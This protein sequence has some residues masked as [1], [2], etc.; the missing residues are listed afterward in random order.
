MKR[1]FDIHLLICLLCFCGIGCQKQSSL[2][3]AKKLVR[4]TNEEVEE[5]KKYKDF[6]ESHQDDKFKMRL[7]VNVL[8]NEYE[9][10]DPK[11]VNQGFESQAWVP[12]KVLYK[13][14]GELALGHKLKM[15]RFTGPEVIGSGTY[16][17]IEGLADDYVESVAKELDGEV[18]SLGI[19]RSDFWRKLKAANAKNG[20]V[21]FARENKLDETSLNIEKHQLNANAPFYQLDMIVDHIELSN[22]V[23]LKN[24]SN[25]SLACEKDL[26]T[27]VSNYVVALHALPSLIGV[28][29][30]FDELLKSRDYFREES[31]L[32]HDIYYMDIIFFN[33]AD[34]LKRFGA[35]NT[36][37]L[38]YRKVAQAIA[39]ETQ[40]VVK[41]LK[42]LFVDLVN[43]SKLRRFSE[44]SD[45]HDQSKNKNDQNTNHQ[46]QLEHKRKHSKVLRDLIEQ[47]M[48]EFPKKS[49]KHFSKLTDQQRRD[50]CSSI[51]GGSSLIQCGD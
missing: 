32:G 12:D 20:F 18:S 2:N 49:Q 29:N 39:Q 26:N 22:K 35:G 6:Y 51:I 24:K 7:N 21:Y 50:L 47:V 27:V 38:E 44:T 11:K 15:R 3:D 48:K 28:L 34:R 5:I 23:T 31:V 45:G 9:N 14:S 13:L 16:Y 42:T 10:A 36:C 46:I 25:F 41:E 8:R 43:I 40:P 1:K 37:D 33:L 19:I 4:V 30:R 17:T